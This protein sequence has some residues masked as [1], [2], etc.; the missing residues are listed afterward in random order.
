MS[1]P[2]LALCLCLFAASA[3]AKPETTEDDG[4]ATK[5]GKTTAVTT[6]PDPD[7]PATHPATAPVRTPAA[8]PSRRWHS[9]LPGMIR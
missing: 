2:L 5:P 3:F 7:A 9:L 6:T 4:P 1:R 8:H